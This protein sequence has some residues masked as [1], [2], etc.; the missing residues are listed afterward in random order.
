LS[1]KWAC[2]LDRWLLYVQYSLLAMSLSLGYMLNDRDYDFYFLPFSIPRS[3]MLVV[4]VTL[5][6]ILCAYRNIKLINRGVRRRRIAI[7]K[8]AIRRSPIGAPFTVFSLLLLPSTVSLYFGNI[9]AH[10][11]LIHA[12]VSIFISLSILSYCV[13]YWVI[14]KN[15]FVRV[16][17]LS[18][19]KERFV[20]LIICLALL[21][22]LVCLCFYL[23]FFKE[24]DNGFKIL[25][26]YWCISVYIS[27]L[28]MVV[29]AIRYKMLRG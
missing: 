16:L 1:G 24:F 21:S 10:Q 7:V 9:S 29:L 17:L 20:I 3:M 15:R 27:T 23:L 26:L 5:L 28:F 14:R 6:P 25:M 13:A 18:K 12:R 19:E 2:Y 8:R 11:L 4:A 22:L